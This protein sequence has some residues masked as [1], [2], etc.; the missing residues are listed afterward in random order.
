MKKSHFFRSGVL[1]LAVA[2]CLL[3]AC[4][5]PDPYDLNKTKPEAL[6][7]SAN[8]IAAAVIRQT[9]IDNM[10]ALEPESISLH[11]NFDLDLLDDYAVYMST[12]NTSADEVSIF[13][14]KEG[15]DSQVIVS[16]LNARIQLKMQTFQKLAPNE[17]EKLSKALLL[18][19]GEYIALLVCSNVDAAHSILIDEYHFPAMTNTTP[20]KNAMPARKGD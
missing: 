14:L 5:A 6:H 8:D 1:L 16:A 10:A 20:K 17:Y 12:V 15:T 13:H 3:S 4:G 18:T 9:S 19:Y 2:L 7:D 11:Y